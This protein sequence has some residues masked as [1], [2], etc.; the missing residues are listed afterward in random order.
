MFEQTL[1]GRGSR[2]V[3]CLSMILAVASVSLGG[4]ESDGGGGD[5]EEIS[6]LGGDDSHRAGQNCQDCHR[7]GGRGDGVFTVAGTV[8]D[9]NNPSVVKANV[10]VRFFQSADLS[11]ALIA[12]IEVDANGN[13]YTTVSIPF[14]TGLFAV[15]IDG[16][17]SS[18]FMSTPITASEGACNSCHDGVGVPVIFIN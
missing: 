17:A 16:A 1:T 9:G 11:S 12:E 5:N 13:F 14:A 4:C 15:V 18:P 3:L 7:S 10:L 6:R 2:A 8:F